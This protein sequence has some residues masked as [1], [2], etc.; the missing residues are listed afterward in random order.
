MGRGVCCIAAALALT[1]TP[2]AAAGH[3]LVS[4]G[5][6]TP[7]ALHGLRVVQRIPALR[8]AEV[9]VAGARGVQRL[10]LRPGIRFVQRVRPRRHTG[11]PTPLAGAVTVPEWQW[12]AAHE[13]LVP[14][15]VQQAASKVTIAVVD[16]GAD[17][18]APSLAAKSPTA[19]NVVSGSAVVKDQVGHGTFVASLAGGTISSPNGLL[20]F[21]GDAN[22]MIVQANRGSTGFTD[23]DE[24]N[25]IVWAVDHGANVVN[26]SLG[27]PETSDVERYAIDYAT[28]KGVLLVAA[29]GNAAQDGNPT[30]YPGALIGRTGLVVGAADTSGKRAPFSTTGRYVDVLAPGVNVL[31]ALAGGIAQSFFVPTT[32][33]GWT[34][35]YGYG[36]GT[37]YAAPEV[38]GAAAL[39][40]AANPSLSAADV[41][42]AIEATASGNGRWTTDLAFGNVNVAAAV[43]RA[44][45]GPAPALVQP[46]PAA[47]TKLS[48]PVKAAKVAPAGK[49]RLR[50]VRAG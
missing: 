35:A 40:M 37:S 27:G 13:D 48:K 21:G 22:L 46:L 26:L 23:V 29:A 19:W 4:V 20:G 50:R 10:R 16:T 33:P 41:A 36:T 9:R 12:T 43:Q 45:G 25:G 24:A 49:K 3:R 44:L 8:V 2:A 11:G 14:P 5:Y 31:G 28:S 47:K 1:Y 34:G 38:A 7:S 42:E 30:I 32:V 18:T 17:L 15:W 6:R 39:V